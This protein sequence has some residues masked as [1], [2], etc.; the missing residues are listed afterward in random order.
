[1]VEKPQTEDDGGFN[2]FKGLGNIFNENSGLKKFFGLTQ[3][4]QDEMP[5]MQGERADD[6]LPNVTE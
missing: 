4:D 6:L 3:E 5:M 2:F 1:M